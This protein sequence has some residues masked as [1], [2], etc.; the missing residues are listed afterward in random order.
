M[1]TV[2]IK[3]TDGK[4]YV[5]SEQQHNLDHVELTKT[6]INVWINASHVIKFPWNNVYFYS[7]DVED[8]KHSS[9]TFYDI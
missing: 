5:F 1:K 2:I 9:L 7:Y 3:C 6:F 4:E 8:N